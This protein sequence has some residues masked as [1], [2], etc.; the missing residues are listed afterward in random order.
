LSRTPARP[1]ARS[2]VR[3]LALVPAVVAA[4]FLAGCSGPEPITPLDGGP[5]VHHDARGAIDHPSPTADG[6]GGDRATPADSGPG[7]AVSTA[8]GNV[9]DVESN[10][11]LGGSDTPQG[12]TVP[13][14]CLAQ[15]TFP[16]ASERRVDLH[17]DFNN[18]SHGVLMWPDGD[19][20]RATVPLENGKTVTYKLVVD[21]QTWTPDPENPQRSQDGN[22]NSVMTVSCPQVCP[23]QPPPDATAPDGFFDWRDG[24]MYFVLLD[25]FNDGDPTNN[26]PEQGVETPGNWQ[27]GDLAGV[28]AKINDGYFS[29]LGVNVL[30]LSSPLDTPAGHNTGDD[31]HEYTGYH[32]YWPGDLTKI[33]EHLGTADLLGQVVQA[34]H[35]KGIKVV[36]DYVMNHV[37]QLSPV[38]QQHPDWFWPIETP[39]GRYCLC[40]QGCS[41]DTAPD[42][43]RCW[44][45]SFLPDFNFTID[46]ARHF[47]VQNAIGLAMSAGVDGLRLD[48][49]KHIEPSWLTDLRAQLNAE[50]TPPGHPFYLIGETFSAD[51]GLIRSYIDPANKLDGQFDFP[52]RAALV[53][54]ILMR[55]GTLYDLD[56]FLTQNDT[57]YGGLS[58]MGTFLGN[59]DLPRMVHLAEDVPQFGEWD[60][61]K[62]RAWDNRPAQPDYD[63]PYERLRVAFTALFTLPGMPLVYYGDEIGM[64]GGGDPDN[65]QFMKWSGV[66]DRQELVRSHVGKLTRI[67]QD[68]PAL[69]FGARQQVWLGN[70][71]YAYQ[72]THG[73]SQVVVVLNR[74]DGDQT[75]SL[76]PPAAGGDY[77]DLLGGGTVSASS[78]TV[79]ARS[80]MI[81]R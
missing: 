69:R 45:D 55:Q 39:D 64:A 17:G 33:E 25:R 32:G 12:C 20:W 1:L 41:W 43:L 10:N 58:V 35:A 70:D 40:G 2:V 66:P 22:D 74:S 18:W 68:N 38:Y 72:L 61:G 53:R 60:G 51:Q 23:G 62:N 81:L 80:S 48:A 5:G 44:F 28:L 79:P 31:G 50:L 73:A 36:L 54:N 11:D 42:N 56:N 78:V 63:R 65:R 15:F 57:F 21:G 4:S 47:S 49:V 24:M 46:D 59:H 19:H 67:R 8:D 14:S 26:N 27:G 7:D 77:T 76:P 34:A 71:V 16:K 13:T 3:S 6:P 9:S 37:H 75:L 30:W 52:L 29:N